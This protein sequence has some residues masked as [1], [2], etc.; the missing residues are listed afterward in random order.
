[1]L[2]PDTSLAAFPK[3]PLNKHVVKAAEASVWELVT[4]GNL[5]ITRRSP[6][7]LKSPVAIEVLSEPFHD[8]AFVSGPPAVPRRRTFP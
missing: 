8:S 5:A 3:Q 6:V 2:K 4:E 1:M 7:S